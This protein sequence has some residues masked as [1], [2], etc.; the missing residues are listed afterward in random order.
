M[1]RSASRRALVPLVELLVLVLLTLLVI[2]YRLFVDLELRDLE[3]EG[4]RMVDRVERCVARDNVEEIPNIPWGY[5]GSTGVGELGTTSDVPVEAGL[6]G[7]RGPSI[8]RGLGGM[9]FRF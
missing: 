3:V 4:A 5:T 7:S 9:V 1:S 2:L 8:S 6:D